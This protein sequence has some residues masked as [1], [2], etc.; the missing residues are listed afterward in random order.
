M[1]P[2][3]DRALIATLLARARRIDHPREREALLATV[4]TDSFGAALGRIACSY[5]GGQVLPE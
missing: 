1:L 2:Y 4:E 5:D 3:I